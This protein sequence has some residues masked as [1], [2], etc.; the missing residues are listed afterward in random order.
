MLL[1]TY[2][3]R[4]AQ[5]LRRPYQT[6]N[7]VEVSRLALLYNFD[8][9][10]KTTGMQVIPVLKANAYGHG[11]E[12]VATAL[13]SRT[14]PYIAVDGYF[15]ALKIQAISRQPVLV[16]G[17]IKPHNFSKMRVQKCTFVVQDEAA[18]HA[19]GK[20]DKKVK[21]HLEINTGMNRNGI[22]AQETQKFA[23]LLRKYPRLQLE[24]VMTH[25][26]DSDGTSDKTVNEPVELFDQC[27]D[28]ILASG[29]KPTLF[30]IGQSAGSLRVKSR[31]ANA[32]RIGLGLYGLNPFP[33]E[34]PQHNTCQDL[35]PAM[36][37]ISTISRINHLQ[38]GDKVSYNYTFT[39]P[40]AMRIG[41]LPLGY[42]EGVSR[43]L[44]NAG[45]VK[46]GTR[47]QPI[48]GRV[49]MNHTMISLEDDTKVGDEVVVY[50][51]N[52]A[53]PNSIQSIAKKYGLFDYALLTGVSSTIRRYLVL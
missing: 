5:R 3:H 47:F 2:V 46:A 14:F 7:R 1:R 51:S 16:M 4:L 28:T 8:F 12:Q 43:A 21:V 48:V 22:P 18:I 25:L 24:G 9:F 10:R 19:L 36:Q 33:A 11:L 35:K 23:E 20:L 37:L 15:E 45:V 49:C 41:V 50:S 26:A 39:A 38:K 40:K 31:F 27:V 34:H 32:V 6:Y 17:M 44:S 13:K 42:Y 30:H 29:F 53:D 52:P